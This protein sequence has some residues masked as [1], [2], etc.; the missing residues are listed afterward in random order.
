MNSPLT[1][2]AGFKVDQIKFLESRVTSFRMDNH[3][4]LATDGRRLSGFDYS[5]TTSQDIDIK[6]CVIRVKIGVV[7]RAVLKGQSDRIDTGAIET[8]TVFQ[9]KQ[10]PKFMVG[11]NGESVE[12]PPAIGGTVLGLA[13]STMRGT[14]L[15]LGAGTILSK[16]FLPVVNPV[17]L[18]RNSVAEV[19]A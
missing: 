8:E 14:L 11:L 13:Y 3:L 5:I 1:P 18:L 19:K 9:L 16:A 7:L 17:V 15:T 2:A 4:N 6:K 12:L 10:L